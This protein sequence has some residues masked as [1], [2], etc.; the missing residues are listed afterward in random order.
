M[1]RSASNRVS[2]FEPWVMNHSGGSGLTI[3]ERGGR[4]E[5]EE[6]AAGEAPPSLIVAPSLRDLIVAKHVYQTNGQL[7]RRG[8]SPFRCRP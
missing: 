2:A 8:D 1:S 6:V 4:G 5:R 3:G 7:H